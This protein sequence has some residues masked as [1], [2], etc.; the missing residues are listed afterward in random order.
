LLAAGL[1]LAVANT[2]GE[3]RFGNALNAKDQPHAFLS[4]ERAEA[5]WPFKFRVREGH[6]LSYS[7]TNNI[8][9][10]LALE[11][12]NVGLE[13]D[14]YSPSLLWNK[15][16]QELRQGRVPEAWKIMKEFERASNNW[17]EG[18]ELLK[19]YRA[20]RLTNYSYG[21]R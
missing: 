9:P 3:Y 1:L 14:P 8:D 17:P 7:N 10:T 21:R 18:A 20:V 19:I 12:L 2:V 6:A 5:V 4:L 13:N 16:M 15:A 11:A